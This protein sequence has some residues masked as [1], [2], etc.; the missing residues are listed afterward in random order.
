MLATH[1]DL[2]EDLGDQIPAAERSFGVRQTVLE[3][4]ETPAIDLP[5]F[6]YV[7]SAE[8]IE[9]LLEFKTI[10]PGIEGRLG[11]SLGRDAS[12]GSRTC[13]SGCGRPTG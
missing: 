5:E 13:H 1:P 2:L 10:S 8:A 6:E 12:P 4:M 7:S 9:A 11:M 3:R